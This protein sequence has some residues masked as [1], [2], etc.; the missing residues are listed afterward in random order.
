MQKT[1]DGN[2]IVEAKPFLKWAGGKGQLIYEIEKRL[3]SEIKRTKTIKKYF[4]PF[5]GGGAL[6]FYLMS[7]YKIKEAFISDINPELILVYNVI[8]NNPDELIDNLRLFKDSYK[9]NG[10]SENKEYFYKVRSNF[11][12]ALGNF[13]FD[14]YSENHISRAAQL[15]FLNKTCFNGLFRVNRKGE[16]NVPFANPKNPLI[17][18]EKNILNASSFLKK[19]TIKCANYDCFEEVMDNESFVYLDPPYRP[20]KGSP[21]LQ[22]SKQVFDDKSQ[23]ELCNFYKRISDKCVNALLSNSDPKNVDKDDNFFDNLY[24][25]FKIDRIP[26]KRMIN[27]KGNKRGPITEILVHNY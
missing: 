13:N 7:N 5:V 9:K 11:N 26:A 18:D 12:G 3:P 21:I 27:S 20:L 4:E 10:E 22:Y 1:F 6:F 2:L 25:N 14:Y 23:I 24:S 15:I 19:T 16:F 17:C 8:K